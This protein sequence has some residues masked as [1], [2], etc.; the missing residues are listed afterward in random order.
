MKYSLC[1]GML[2]TTAKLRG[3]AGLQQLG[4]GTFAVLNLLNVGRLWRQ[5]S[6]SP[7]VNS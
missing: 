7:L 5:K 1:D 2:N 6:Q 3:L 4:T